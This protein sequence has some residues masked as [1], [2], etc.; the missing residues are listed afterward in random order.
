[1]SHEKQ[2]TLRASRVATGTVIS[3]ILGYVRDMMVA[4]L[5]GAGFV[6]DAFYAAY[7]IPNLLRRLLG[8]GALSAS[9]IP[10]FSEYLSKKTKKETQEF[11]NIVFTALTILLSVLTVLGII[12]APQIAK[13]I[14]Y[15]F[16]SNP[17]KLAL[18]IT[19]TKLMFPFLLF[20]C[21]A[22]LLMGILNTLHKFFIPAIAPASLSVSEVGYI[23]AIAPMLAQ[24]DQIR[25]LALSVLVGGMFQFIVQ[26]PQLKKL[27]W[28]LKWKF[29]LN[30][31]GL[32]KV[33]F[34]MVP[35]II[36]LSVDQ[37]N[38][39]V[40]TI[41]GSFLE[42]GSITA[43][44][45]S[46]RVMQMPLAIFGLAFA[47]VSL[48]AMSKAVSEKNIGSLKDTL[49]YS[50]RFIIFILTPAA[51][52]LMVIGLPIIHLLF[53][54]GN[55]DAHASY[56]TNSALFFY[57]LGLPAYAITKVLAS[58]FF[59]QQ[60]T[61]T[62]VKIAAIA[63][64]INVVLC[65]ILMRILG[66]GGLALATATSSIFNA[67]ALAVVL[68]KRIGALGIEKIIQ[69]TFKTLSASLIMGFAAYWI[70]FKVLSHM[71]YFGVFV[72]IFISAAVYFLL[73]HVFQI[74]ERKQLFSLFEKEN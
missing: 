25:G 72:A 23:L 31:P 37:I 33:A 63:M 64:V 20:I 38:A 60:D 61:K 74:H 65:I 16:T 36:G 29:K 7:R 70:A 66:V 71:P 40:N 22:A 5:F 69:T 57:S 21:L 34:L 3:R 10:V 55:F 4:N 48:P 18:T 52:G 73:S 44:Y 26:W 41:C 68:R 58:A 28:T 27:K 17:E 32:K 42:Q 35:A 9:F 53:E 67:I 24:G 12:F 30:H 2:L 45:Y 19:L 6:A 49:N 43:L 15:G 54:R 62:P 11:L 50:I 56:L 51:V 59:S 39:F 13:L 47:S 8:E 1:M 14:A 46:N